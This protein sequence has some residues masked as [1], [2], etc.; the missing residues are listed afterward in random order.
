MSG[1][2]T[3]LNNDLLYQSWKR[4]TQQVHQIS[5][6]VNTSSLLNSPPISAIIQVPTTSLP[7]SSVSS[8]F[9]IA[10]KMYPLPS[11]PPVKKTK[12]TEYFVITADEVI[13]QKKEAAASNIKQE[14][15][16]QQKRLELLKLGELCSPCC[17]GKVEPA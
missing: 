11:R 15:I 12:K 7:V 16:K 8:A 14:E 9:S 6:K 2:N 10:N 3:R 4:Y 1:I 17:G 5:G 13:H